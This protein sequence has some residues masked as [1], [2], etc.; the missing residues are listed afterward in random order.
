MRFKAPSS[1]IPSYK[2]MNAYNIVIC[3]TTHIYG[4]C[5]VQNEEDVFNP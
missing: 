2:K 1:K 4:V 5:R 3:N